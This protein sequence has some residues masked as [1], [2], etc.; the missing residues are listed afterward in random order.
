MAQTKIGIQISANGSQASAEIDKIKSKIQSMSNQVSKGIEAAAAVAGISMMGMAL[1][2]VATTAAQTADRLTSIRSR[3]NLVNDGTQT[4]ADLM[5]KIYDAAQRTRGGY[6]DMADSVAKL[7]MLAKDAFSSNDEAIEFVEQMNKQF[8]IS[9]ASIQES[10]AAMYQLTQSMAAG[11]LQGD[12][13]HSIMENAPM[14]AQSIAKEMG[15]TVGELKNVSSEGMITADV[16]KNALFNSAE[17]TN[18][19]FA[20]MPMTFAEVGQSIQNEAI[21]AFQPVLEQLSSLT[22]DG[23]FQ[24]FVGGVAVAFRAMAAAAQVSISVISGGFSAMG[25]AISTVTNIARSFGTL[26]ITTMPRVSAAVVAVVAGFTL[27]RTVLALCSTQ[28]AALTVRTVALRVAE[29]ATSVA[30]KALAVAT[31]VVRTVMAGTAVVM[32]LLTVGTATL[33]GLYTALRGATLGASAAQAVLNAVMR[34]NPVGIVIT[35]I[36]VLIGVYVTASAA[37]NGFGE[38]MR[39]VWNTI[40]HTV[41]WGVN[42]A[43]SLINMLISALNA[44]GNKVASVFGTT[45]S[46]IDQINQISGDSAQEFAENTANTVRQVFDGVSGGGGGDTASAA[47]G[48]DVGGGA[49]GGGGH[50]G[51]GGGGGA[52]SGEDLA[53]E[54]KQT[55]EKILQSFLE[56]MGKKRELVEIDYKNE[57]DE[58]NK[59][60]DANE[61]YQEDLANLNAVYADKRIK[62]KQEEV[63]KIL[64]IE[65]TVRDYVKDFNFNTADK[66]STGSVSPMTQ[67]KKDYEDGINEIVDKY[68][69][70]QDSF[71]KMDKMEQEAYL[72]ALK[73]KGVAFELNA[74]GEISFEDMKNAELLAKQKEFNEKSAQA[75]RELQEQKWEID[76][77][78]RTQNFEALQTALDDEYVAQQQ[79]YDTMKEL[80]NDYRQAVMDSHWNGLQVM[81]DTASAGVDK[82]QEGISGLLQGTMSVTQAFQNM[83]KAILKTISD[84]IAQWIA[85]Q[86]KQAILGKMLRSQETAASIAAAQAQ[87][88]AWSALAQQMAMATWGASAEAGWAA[89]STSTSAGLAQSTALSSAGGMSG[90]PSSGTVSWDSMKGF[91]KGMLRMAEGG[92]AYGPTYAQIGEGRYEEAVI[93]LSDTVFSR[94]GEG[95]NRA[96]GNGV[97]GGI[98]LNVNAIDAQSFG[99]FLES[100][101]GRAMRQFLVNQDREFISTAGTW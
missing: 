68:A 43:I 94:L 70:M 56:M 92:L 71:I 98:T 83:G 48:G 9:G 86:L 62:A 55:H 19:K 34:A 26:F 58:L 97:G 53:K 40:V 12:E 82:L 33:R 52:S 54:A 50:G 66:D 47:G 2:E 18:A 42:Q 88:P 69:D 5:N 41:T 16:I 61:N 46:A 31:G 75:H 67:L 22:A 95:I 45:F 74:E 90:M 32:S 81:W 87:L 85:G 60:K 76:E 27:Y 49:S 93:P 24:D 3:L 78:M 8:K 72:K 84:S 4:T 14:L 101:G 64:D 96:G 7:N 89:W 57:L 59:S 51:S 29:V 99:D 6:D 17:E 63:K 80:M 28:V 73:D 79:H 11:K 65:N 21:M 20:E 37:A 15:M 91:D 25:V 100:R 36:G 77:A 44:V 10:S 1:K 13:F 23:A 39:S 38:T 35:I 30:T